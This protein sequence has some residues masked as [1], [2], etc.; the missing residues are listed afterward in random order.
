MSFEQLMGSV[1]QMATAVD[2]LAAIGAELQL[3]ASGADADPS[4][5]SALAA[6]STAA[7][8]ADLDALPPEQQKMALSLIRLFF[9]QAAD[10]LNHPERAPGWLVNDPDVLDGYGRASAMVPVRLGAAPELANVTSFLDVGTGVGLLAVSATNV[11]PEATVVGI[12]V[13]ETSLE[14]ARKNVA[15][16]GRD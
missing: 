7:G 11:W 16:A 10:L 15:A 13:W 4:V 3:K 1:S 2:T 6:V 8:L 14:R 5:E 9:A 12:D